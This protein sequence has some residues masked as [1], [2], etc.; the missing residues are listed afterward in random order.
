MNKSDLYFAVIQECKKNGLNWNDVD[1][2]KSFLDNNSYQLISRDSLLLA[3]IDLDELFNKGFNSYGKSVAK[4]AI[5]FMLLPLSIILLLATI[6]AVLIPLF[7][8]YPSS[9]Y[10]SQIKNKLFNGIKECLVRDAQDS[11]TNFYDATSFKEHNSRKYD[12]KFEIIPLDSKSCF[13]A[14]A[15][16]MDN[17]HTWFV[18]DY[19][20]RTE[21]ASKK[22]GD[23]SKPGCEE[24]NTW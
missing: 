15:V 23:S 11:S 12:K 2:K 13:K 16:P 20:L 9:F 22:C 17:E 19:N 6:S 1:Q 4:S 24:G 21:T 7:T 8:K 3:S 5:G 10:S 18:L 14:K